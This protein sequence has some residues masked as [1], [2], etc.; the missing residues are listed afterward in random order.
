[1]FR[2]ISNSEIIPDLYVSNVI[3]NGYMYRYLILYDCP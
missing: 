1:M 2:Y 3:G